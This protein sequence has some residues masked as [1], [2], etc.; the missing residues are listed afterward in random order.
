MMAV[1]PSLEISQTSRRF[2]MKTKTWFLLTFILI[3]I[4]S[5]AVAD[6]GA[7]DWLSTFVVDGE[8]L[9]G[10]EQYQVQIGVGDEADIV[11]AP[12]SP[13]EYSVKM[14][15]ISSEEVPAARLIHGNGNTFYSWTIAVD[16]N[17]NMMPPISRSAILRWNPDTLG[18]GTFR[19]V[20]GADPS[21]ITLVQDMRILNQYN[22][23]GDSPLYLTIVFVPAF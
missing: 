10:V 16:P 23:E 11:E 22:L 7:S 17:G 6:D 1:R 4:A 15:L 12:P 20:S 18:E 9:G 13:P 2:V 5:P 21:G 8:P 14:D 19:L 3:F